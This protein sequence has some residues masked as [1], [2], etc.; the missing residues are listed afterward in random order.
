MSRTQRIVGLVIGLLVVAA[1]VL[2]ALNLRGRTE[3]AASMEASPSTSSSATPEAS[4]GGSSPSQEASASADP[5]APTS[6]EELAILV[7]IEEQVEEI[8]GLEP[9]DIGPPEIISRVQLGEELR[10]IFDEEYPL[11]ERERDNIAL[12]AMGLLGPDEDVAEL[13]LQLLGEDVLGFYDDQGKRMVLVSDSG[14]DALAK[15]TYA[16]EYT[17][18]LQDATFGLDSLETN[19]DGEDDRSLARVALQEG[20]A[21]TTMLAWAFANLTQAELGDLEEPVPGTADIPSWLEAQLAFPYTYGQF[22]ASQLAGGDP[23]APDFTEVDAAFADPPSST[24]QIIDINKW[25]AGEEPLSVEVPD[26]AAALGEGWEEV[27]ETP[28]G[29]AS[30]AITL[31]FFGLSVPE[32]GR[33][34]DGW[35]GDRMVVASGPDDAFALLWRLEWDAPGGGA[36]FAEAYE[37]VVD[38]VD[39]AASVRELSDG[40]VLVVHASSQALHDQTLDIAGE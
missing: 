17:H 15:L 39:F 4:S 2:V 35:G 40:S 30:I 9:A 36:E 3:I 26:L 29:Q 32:A 25:S 16:H 20:D 31:E 12:R 8:R 1:I 38:G 14:L 27:D 10:R 13:Q 28:V 7:Q 23:L 6:E 19:A 18:A 5:S 33:A 11:D 34:A 22:W 24:E 21:S 37:S